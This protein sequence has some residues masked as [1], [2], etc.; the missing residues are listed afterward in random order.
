[1]IIFELLFF[2]I[3]GAWVVYSIH[4]DVKNILDKYQQSGED[5]QNDDEI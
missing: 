4:D 2:L 1:M 5:N 3:V